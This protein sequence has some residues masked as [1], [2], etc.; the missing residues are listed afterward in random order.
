M[1]QMRYRNNRPGRCF[2]GC[3]TVL[4]LGRPGTSKVSNRQGRNNSCVTG[5]FTM[6]NRFSAMA[7]T[8]CLVMLFGGVAFAQP[9]LL[10]GSFQDGTNNWTIAGGGAGTDDR[11]AAMTGTCGPVPDGNRVLWVQGTGPCTV[12]QAITG[13]QDKYRYDLKF[14]VN[15]RSE[16]PIEEVTRGHGLSHHWPSTRCGRHRHPSGGTKPA[17]LTLGGCDPATF[18]RTR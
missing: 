14:F 8:L 3:Y 9:S 1:S 13:L 15:I 12:S 4:G 16:R 2:S 11:N 18:E 17:C 7:I 10:N 5:E 6:H